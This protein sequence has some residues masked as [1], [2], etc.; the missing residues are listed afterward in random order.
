MIPK[1]HQITLV[2]IDTDQLTLIG[3]EPPFTDL[4][5]TLDIPKT[6]LVIPG[7]QR[8]KS[9]IGTVHDDT[10]ISS[11]LID[12][13]PEND[14]HHIYCAATKSFL[15]DIV[16]SPQINMF[17]NWLMK[18]SHVK[19]MVHTVTKWN[20]MSSTGTADYNFIDTNVGQIDHRLI[21]INK[22]HSTPQVKE[23]VD[24]WLKYLTRTESVVEFWDPKGIKAVPLNKLTNMT[25]LI[26]FCPVLSKVFDLNQI[27]NVKTTPKSNVL[28]FYSYGDQDEIVQFSVSLDSENQDHLDWF[29]WVALNHFRYNLNSP[30]NTIGSHPAHPIWSKNPHDPIPYDCILDPKTSVILGE[31]VKLRFHFTPLLRLQRELTISVRHCNSESESWLPL[32]LDKLDLESIKKNGLDIRLNSTSSLWKSKV[33]QLLPNNNNKFGYSIH[34]SPLYSTEEIHIHSIPIKETHSSSDSIG[35]VPH[36][37]TFVMILKLLE[38]PL[39]P[40]KLLVPISPDLKFVEYTINDS[41]RNVPYKS[42]ILSSSV[43]S[44]NNLILKL[45]DESFLMVPHHIVPSF[46]PTVK[47][48]PIEMIVKISEAINKMEDYVDY[49]KRKKKDPSTRV[50]GFTTESLSKVNRGRGASLHDFKFYSTEFLLPHLVKVRLYSDFD[51]TKGVVIQKFDFLFYDNVKGGPNRNN[52]MF[53]FEQIK[54]HFIPIVKPHHAPFISSKKPLRISFEGKQLTLEEY[55]L[56]FNTKPGAKSISEL[57]DF[58]PMLIHSYEP[59]AKHND[60]FQLSSEPLPIAQKLITMCKLTLPN[61]AYQTDTNNKLFIQSLDDSTSFCTTEEELEEIREMEFDFKEPLLYATN[62]EFSQV[63]NETVSKPEI[64]TKLTEFSQVTNVTL[65][66][67]GISTKLNDFQNVPLDDLLVVPSQSKNYS[68]VVRL[69][70]PT[71]FCIIPSEKDSIT[72]KQDRSPLYQKTLD[73]LKKIDPKV[74]KLYNLYFTFESKEGMT[75]TVEECVIPDSHLKFYFPQSKIVDTRKVTLFHILI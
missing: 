74:I 32:S 24:G 29:F 40:G 13:R 63:T 46:I 38:I 39:L 21:Y 66:K 55:A 3:T 15:C 44:A 17:V 9:S 26:Y 33:I 2:H 18:E 42:G 73:L 70:Q 49:V 50:Q 58:F 68:K 43:D 57:N 56:G 14:V 60:L 22:Y 65:S 61:M 62:I 75:V 6:A 27:Y 72:P 51:Q 64:S 35:Y 19:S 48:E 45:E 11:L 37:L 34:S 7:V 71:H 16:K 25:H 4:F 28:N 52:Q 31:K 69:S 10:L 54:R 5:E 53:F 36:N 47:V 1:L 67:P 30:I 23:Q 12:S 20:P 41:V 8:T 59:I